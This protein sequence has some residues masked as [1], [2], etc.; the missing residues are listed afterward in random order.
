MVLEFV[1]DKAVK[2][3]APENVQ[4]V[5]RGVALGTYPHLAPRSK[6]A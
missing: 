3:K 5:P 4:S 2:M 6:K 1:L